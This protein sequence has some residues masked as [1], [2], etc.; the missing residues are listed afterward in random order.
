M[1]KHFVEFL[2]PGTFVSEVTSKE[3]DSWD[4]DKAVEMARSIKE[5]HSAVPYGFRFITRERKNNELDSKVT[6]HSGIYYL[7]GKVETYEMVV[8]R[9]DPK[10]ETLRWNMKHNNIERVIIN[11]NSWK[12]TMPLNKEDTVLEWSN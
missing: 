12:V 10:E 3:I 5:R 4:V 8:L 7:G 2:S 1:K 9:D 11:T 6:K